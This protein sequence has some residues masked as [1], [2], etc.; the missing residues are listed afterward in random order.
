V[1]PF[2]RLLLAGLG[3]LAFFA[4]WI[5]VV[6]ATTP[7]PRFR[8]TLAF[9]TP[10]GG[11][12][13]GVVLDDR[14]EIAVRGE[15]QLEGGDG[16]QGVA[17]LRMWLGAHQPTQAVLPKSADLAALVESAKREYGGGLVLHEPRPLEGPHEGALPP[18]R[19]A[20]AQGRA[21]QKR[22]AE[23]ERWL[24]MPVEALSALG[25]LMASGEMVRHIIASLFRVASGFALGTLL[26]IPLG[27]A[28]G[29]FARVHASVNSLI[30]CLRPI[31]PIAWLP[32]AALVFKGSD[33]AAIF[34][35]FLASFFPIAVATAAAVATVDLKYRRSAMNFGVHGL[36]AA[37][38]VIVPAVLPSIL[39]G[40]R[41]ALG[42][43]WVVVV[44]AEMLGVEAGLGYLVLD[45]RNQLRY[46][47]VV[48][49]MIVIGMIGL[50]LD[51]TIRKFE[52]VELERRGL[53]AR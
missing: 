27:L 35:I 41:I 52:R 14:G 38:Y 17:T 7:P 18:E 39:T 5:V 36:A 2:E 11:V 40:L 4:L 49:A 29:S 25:E 43:S 16:S 23:G 20:E 48:A 22:T 10:R 28:M 3:F 21:L 53:S 1:K 9:S 30:Q 19:E 24:P 8:A 15:I 13:G 26:G 50:L 47:R 45:A 12:V 34:L 31:S 46:D 37:R 33:K 42:I 51:V 6:P 32:V 44:A